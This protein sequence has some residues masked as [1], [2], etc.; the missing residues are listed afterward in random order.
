MP[1]KQ[2][3]VWTAIWTWLTVNFGNSYFT[4]VVAAVLTSILRAYLF[5]NK[6]K[7]RYVLI[8]SLICGLLVYVSVPALE[9]LI[10]HGDY[11]N[12]LGGAF[13]LIGTE[14]LRD[15]LI[16]WMGVKIKGDNNDHQ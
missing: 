11:S 2:P 6:K 10:G 12:M 9:H 4:S 16:A 7:F 1:Y 5:R 13:G 8:D 14:K 15:F 3:D